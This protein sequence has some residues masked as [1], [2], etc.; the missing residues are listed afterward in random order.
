MRCQLAAMSS[1]FAAVDAAAVRQGGGRCD[2]DGGSGSPL[3][4]GR[5]LPTRSPSPAVFTLPATRREARALKQ[6]VADAVAN[7]ET[8]SPL[9]AGAEAAHDAA[10][11]AASLAPA[12]GSSPL[13]SVAAAAA[14]A[15]A[16]PTPV[17]AAP[18]AVPAAVTGAVSAPE[19]VGS[20]LLHAP[21]SGIDGAGIDAAGTSR[22]PSSG[23][24][25]RSA[26]AA[27]TC[28]APIVPLFLVFVRS[29]R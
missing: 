16:V 10:V 21:R 5:R 6:K 24:R 1:L 8:P 17:A 13:S 4:R 22:P 23:P 9:A 26:M 7:A 20:A 14:H 25:A 19:S 28:A 18:P 27:C 11:A 2:V 12:R 15:G 3:P 29:L